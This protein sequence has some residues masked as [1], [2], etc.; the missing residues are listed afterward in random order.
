MKIRISIAAMCLLGS[1]SASHAAMSFEECAA[2]NSGRPAVY[3][4]T[5]VGADKRKIIDTLEV[6]SRATV[7]TGEDANVRIQIERAFG[8]YAPQTTMTSKTEKATGQVE[9]MELV[10]DF[11]TDLGTILSTPGKSLYERKIHYRQSGK[12]WKDGPTR[13]IQIEIKDNQP[14]LL[15]G[16]SLA[17]KTIEIYSA[18]GDGS[19]G[20]RPQSRI[21]YAPSAMQTIRWSE[22]NDKEIIMRDLVNLEPKK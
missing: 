19:F 8:L 2:L 16:C 18:K 6:K 5:Y 15:N 13:K 20:D 22:V 12:D 7:E 10:S 11:G 4:Q 17:T 1:S 9:T 3:T 14:A 21:I